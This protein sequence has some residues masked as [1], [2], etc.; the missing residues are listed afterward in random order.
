MLFFDIEITSR[1]IRNLSVKRRTPSLWI[2]T[3]VVLLVSFTGNAS[4]TISGDDPSTVLIIVNDATPPEAGT[5]GIGASVWVGQY[6]ATARGVPVSNICH[7]N[8]AG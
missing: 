1:L 4:T 2:I 7:I 5:N 8:F 6:Y 3:C